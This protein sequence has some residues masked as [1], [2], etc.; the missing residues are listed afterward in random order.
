MLSKI[1]IVY[2]YWD[3]DKFMYAFATE[4]DAEEFLLSIAEEE[5]RRFCV[6]GTQDYFNILKFHRDFNDAENKNMS[7]AGYALWLAGYTYDIKEVK[8]VFQV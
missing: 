3:S 7:I 8:Y 6:A 1:Y 4:I 5:Y 2:D